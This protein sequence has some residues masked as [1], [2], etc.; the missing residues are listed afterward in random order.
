MADSKLDKISEDI[1]ELKVISG[2]QSEILE[3]LT[4]SVEHHVKRSDTLEDLYAMLREE[5]LKLKSEQELTKQLLAAN[6][7]AQEARANE[8]ANLITNTLNTIFYTLSAVGAVLLALH[9]FGVFEKLL[10]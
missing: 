5:Q 6:I 7:A 2:R 3:R 9:E 8:K 1:V 10:K 4:E